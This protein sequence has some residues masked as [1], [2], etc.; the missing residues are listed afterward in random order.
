MLKVAAQELSSIIVCYWK[1]LCS[2][3][4]PADFAVHLCFVSHLLT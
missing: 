4:N 3:T 1:A 2:K